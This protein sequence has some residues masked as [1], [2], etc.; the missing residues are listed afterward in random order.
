VAVERGYGRGNCASSGRR[1]N[2]GRR[3]AITY[4]EGRA[5]EQGNAPDMRCDQRGQTEL[6]PVYRHAAWDDGGTNP[7][8]CIASRRKRGQ[9][10]S[11]DTDLH[12][13]GCKVQGRYSALNRY[14]VPQQRF[15]TLGGDRT[16][17]SALLGTSRKITRFNCL[18]PEHC[19]VEFV[20]ALPHGRPSTRSMPL[21]WCSAWLHDNASTYRTCRDPLDAHGD[22]FLVLCALHMISLHVAARSTPPVAMTAR[23]T[24]YTRRRPNGCQLTPHSSIWR[25]RAWNFRPAAITP[26]K[27]QCGVATP[28]PQRL[29]RIETVAPF[30]FFS[31]CE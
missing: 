24:A 31:T 14:G 4:G 20:V 11:K 5:G 22:R 2:S 28:V 30:V 18:T 3:S 15:R 27:H 19:T 13:C 8:Q 10:E 1:R 6:C 21:S 25:W 9:P 17:R 26:N 7:R 12:R 29:S 23:I 16:G